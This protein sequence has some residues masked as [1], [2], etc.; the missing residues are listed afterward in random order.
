MRDKLGRFA[1]TGGGIGGE[2]TSKQMGQVGLGGGMTTAQ[3]TKQL[4]KDGF[5]NTPKGIKHVSQLTPGQRAKLG[6]PERPKANGR[7]KESFTET[8][9]RLK[10]NAQK[11][12]SKNAHTQA[13]F[14]KG[15][16]VS[17]RSGMS[18]TQFSKLKAKYKF[19]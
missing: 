16:D 4:A 17:N 11:L 2:I 10:T 13:L 19:R 1:S 5:Y 14:A 18:K 12:A 7:A 8:S 9:K 3:A 6:V 15:I